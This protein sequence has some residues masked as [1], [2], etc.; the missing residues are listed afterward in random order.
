ME[1][2]F[3][4]LGM[5]P[6]P[7]DIGRQRIAEPIET[8]CKHYFVIEEDEVEARKRLRHLLVVNSPK[9]DRREA[10]V[11]RGGKGDFFGADRGR[12]CIRA[13]QKYDCVG[14]RDQC[15]D[16]L[17]PILKGINLCPIDQ[18]LEAT[19]FQRGFKPIRERHVLARI[20]DEDFGCGLMVRRV[21][22]ICGHGGPP[23]HTSPCPLGQNRETC[24][25]T[26]SR[27]VVMT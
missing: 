16:A 24:A 4:V 26:L 9:H 6:D 20:G 18:H 15:L 25:T 2:G 3:A 13:E 5:L 22:S 10:F 19:L 23:A 1:G 17:P 27:A 8:V 21:R 14:L 7:V 11:Q 12:Y